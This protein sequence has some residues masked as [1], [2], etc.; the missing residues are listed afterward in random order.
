MDKPNQLNEI[1]LAK[2]RAVCQ[3]YIDHIATG[4]SEDNDYDHYIFESALEAIFGPD[5]WDFINKTP[6]Q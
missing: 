5:V 4:G 2:L 3:Q 1:S 6:D